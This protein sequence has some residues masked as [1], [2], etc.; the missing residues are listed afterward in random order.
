MVVN[1]RDP[2]RGLGLELFCR[3]GDAH[4]SWNHG[5][6]HPDVASEDFA[7]SRASAQIPRLYMTRFFNAI[8]PVQIPSEGNRTIFA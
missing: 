6:S 8:R 3:A 4:G 1:S 5:P 7:S 2:K